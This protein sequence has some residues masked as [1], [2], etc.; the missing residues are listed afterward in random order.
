[1]AETLSNAKLASLADRRN[2]LTR[3]AILDAALDTLE[4]ASVG[5][6]TV[7]AVAKHANISERTVFRYFASRDEFLDA[8]ADA[9]RVEMALPEPPRTL[10]ELRGAPRELYR[11]F[12]NKRGLVTAALHSELFHRMRETQAKTRW[13]A[14]RALLDEAA[15]KRSDGERRIATANIRYFLAASTWHYYRFYFGFSLKE[16]I[17]CAEAAIGQALDSLGKRLSPG[18]AAGAMGRLPRTRGAP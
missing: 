9:L 17:A 5:E 10:E 2:D 6:L 1:M 16:T 7:R 18:R 15:P 12:E 4:R 11:A 13:L 8:V 14:I 3:Q